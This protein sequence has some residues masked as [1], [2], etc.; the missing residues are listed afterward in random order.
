LH[1]QDRISL[2]YTDTPYAFEEN[3]E[4]ISLYADKLKA[5]AFAALEEDAILVVVMKAYHAD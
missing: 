3:F 1:I 2:V 4:I 5:A